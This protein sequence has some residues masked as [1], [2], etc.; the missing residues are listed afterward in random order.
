MFHV[1]HRRHL[2]LS[3]YEHQARR[4]SEVTSHSI[5]MPV[6]GVEYLANDFEGTV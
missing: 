3:K 2:W 6:R 4:A 1:E 5:E